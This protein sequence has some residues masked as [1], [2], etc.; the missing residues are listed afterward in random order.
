MF[1]AGAYDSTGAP[2]SEGA[3]VAAAP[4][5]SPSAPFVSTVFDTLAA[6]QRVPQGVMDPQDPQY[7]RPVLTAPGQGSDYSKTGSGMGSGHMPHPNS[8]EQAPRDMTGRFQ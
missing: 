6:G 5:S 1:G 7:T 8:P 2:G 3:P 4:A